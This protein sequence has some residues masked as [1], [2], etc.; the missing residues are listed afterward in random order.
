MNKVQ[1]SEVVDYVTY[2]EKRADFRA[3]AMREKDARRIHVGEYLTFLFENHETILYQIQE[4]IRTERM[5]KEADIQHEIKTYN[6]LL[7]DE[8]ELGCTLLVEIEDAKT[9]AEKLAEWINLPEKIY[10]DFEDGSRTYA[11]M[12]ARQRDEVK[13]S[14]VQFLKFSCNGKSPIAIGV[15]HIAL[16]TKTI[17]SDA[18]RA[19]LHKD[20]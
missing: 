20:L 16:K 1:R 12:D 5:V 17:L 2:E 6:E 18:Q 19:A 7:G 13:I 15:E 14:S 10:L 11:K 9:R 8:G 3:H 4:V